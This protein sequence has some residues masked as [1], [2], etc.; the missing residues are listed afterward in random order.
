MKWFDS[1]DNLEKL[2]MKQ[3]NSSDIVEI[4]NALISKGYIHAVE[5]NDLNTLLVSPIEEY[6][7]V[8]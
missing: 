7:K 8:K 6:S 1:P 3:M 5:Y 4:G 2:K